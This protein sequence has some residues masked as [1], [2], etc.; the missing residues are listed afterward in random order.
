MRARISDRF[1]ELHPQRQ[2]AEAELAALQAAVP[3][4]MDPSLLNEIPY[5]GAILLDL[6]LALK[7]RLAVR[8]NTPTRRR[9]TI[10]ATYASDPSRMSGMGYA[11]AVASRRPSGLNG[12]PPGL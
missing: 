5:A 12:A 6:P 9:L 4:A 1:T 11:P 8:A 3:T 10:E 2:D 7:A